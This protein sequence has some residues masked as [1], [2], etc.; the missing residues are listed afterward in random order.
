VFYEEPMLRALLGNVLH[1]G[2]LRTTTQ[3]GRLLGIESGDRVLDIACGPGGSVVHLVDTFGCRVT[4]VDFSARSIAEGKTA[5][6]ASA[7]A[8]RAQFAVGDAECLPFPDGVFDVVMIECS[9]CL[10]PDK[11]TAAGEMRRVL[12]PGGRIGVADLAIEKPL[13]SLVDERLAW[14]ACVAGAHPAA[15]YERLLKDA[16][17]VDLRLADASWALTAIVEEVGRNVFLLDV[18]AGL[19]KL[20]DLPITPAEVRDWLREARR[21]IARGVT[22]YIL[23]T[24][25]RQN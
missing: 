2:G 1:P 13:P 18:A 25:R 9:L 17:F 5:V 4:G 19:G 11:K 7:V 12:R 23:L 3:L 8:G 24:G 10:I 16:G 20:P 6:G 21:W 14:V 15:G 22:R